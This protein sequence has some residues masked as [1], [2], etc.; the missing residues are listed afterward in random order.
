MS[1]A[2]YIA[3][4]LGA[5]ALFLMMPRS[6]FSPRAL[7]AL[8][9]AA[10]LGGLWLFLARRLPDDWG[11]AGGGAAMTYYYIFSALGIGSAV[12]V[13]T[14]TKPV[15][16]ALWFVMV[17][18]ST[19][20]MFLLLAADFMA[21]AMIIIYGGA[22]LVTYVFVIMLAAQSGGAGD[23]TGPESP[24]YDRIAWEPVGAICAG[25][26]LLAVLLTVALPA[27]GQ[28]ALSP[29]PRAAAESSQDLIAGKLTNR[30]GKRIADRMGPEASQIPSHARD[31]SPELYNTERIGLALFEGHPLALEL[32]GV[33]LLVALVGA[34]VIARQHVEDE[35]MLDEAVAGAGGAT[36]HPTIEP[37]PEHPE[38]V[39]SAASGRMGV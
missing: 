33:I 6:G 26:L 12:R 1:Y 22:I 13:I 36:V 5:V 4:A 30:P 21:F 8:L 37:G 17:I 24:P 23:L 28:A 27:P 20:G 32:A 38:V 29:N 10:T 16:S 14:H 2:L 3:S 31:D 35:D 7:G 18:L 15:Y 34:V 25:F 9:G 39:E 19:A 11:I